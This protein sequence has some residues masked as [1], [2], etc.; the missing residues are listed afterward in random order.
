MDAVRA[1]L[2]R[3]PFTEASINRIIRTAD[4][5]RGSF[6]QYFADK[7]DMLDY[8]LADYRKMFSKRVMTSL[9]QSGGDL[10]RMLL[11][12]LDY[13]YEIATNKENGALFRN[14]FSDIRINSG[15]LEQRDGND[16]FGISMNELRCH[17][18]TGA[19]NILCDKD[20]ED[21]LGVLLT[22][23]G[24]AFAQVFFDTSAYNERRARYAAR[25]ELIKRGFL[26]ANNR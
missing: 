4:I 7:Q 11:E 14:L 15:F 21:M 13:S 24:E 10:F 19:L 12:I 16:P 6:Y 9:K 25:L 23:A 3:V 5:S 17:V 22:L 8:L 20:F 2:A 26:R 18:D 1:E